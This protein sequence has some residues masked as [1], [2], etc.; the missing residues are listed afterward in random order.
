MAG[1]TFAHGF[2]VLDESLTDPLGACTCMD[3][4][5]AVVA[6]K[7]GQRAVRIYFKGRP[8]PV[9]VAKMATLWSARG[10]R[11]ILGNE[12]N[13]P[14]EGFGGG[15]A[16]YAAWF[17]DVANRCAPTTRLYYAGIS[18]GVA[19]WTAYY[20]DPLARQAVQRAAG[21]CAHA[22][23]DVGDLIAGVATVL[24][25]T[26]PDTPVWVGEWNFGAGRTVDVT[27]WAPVHVPRFLDWCATE[28]RIEGATWFAW[29]WPR[30]DMSLPTPVDAAGTAIET[31][32]RKWRPKTVGVKGIDT[33]N[34]QRHVDCRAVKGSGREFIIAKASE[35][36]G[37]AGGA[38]YIDPYFKGTWMDAATADLVRGAYHFAQPDGASPAQSVGTLKAAIDAAGGLRRTGKPVTVCIYSAPWFLGAHNLLDHAPSLSQYPL[39]D[40]AYQDNL[41]PTP[42]GWPRIFI[43]QNTAHGT[44]PGVEGDCDE[45]VFEG[46]LEELRALGDFVMLD[47][48]AGSSP[49]LLTWAAE[50]LA[51]ASEVFNAEPVPAEPPPVDNVTDA[52]NNLFDLTL[53]PG[54]FTEERRR[55]AQAAIQ[56]LKDALA[57]EAA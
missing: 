29:K 54:P 53:K 49:D 32:I 17:I 2:H 14:S 25:V 39:V 35:D 19:G 3:T 5:G 36:P 1:V 51:L 21:V 30:P 41:P 50:W 28:P 6:E 16:D 40:A 27:A 7:A 22:Y 24:A 13:L 44:V 12:P 38:P 18:P 34:W 26:P 42:A 9:L 31:E 57:K 33:S 56:T 47:L 43:W 52:E 15:P 11:V 8:S 46:T 55:S 4:V 48:E 45:D 23:G 20:T 37:T 10:Y